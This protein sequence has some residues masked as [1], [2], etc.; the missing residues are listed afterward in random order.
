MALASCFARFA[1]SLLAWFCCFLS[2]RNSSLVISTDDA[3]NLDMFF[4]NSEVPGIIMTVK[5]IN[6]INFTQRFLK[7]FWKGETD[8][9]QMPICQASTTESSCWILLCVFCFQ[10]FFDNDL[11]ESQFILSS[12]AARCIDDKPDR[13]VKVR[14]LF[15][16]FCACKNPLH[17][18]SLL[19]IICDLHSSLKISRVQNKPKKLSNGSARW[20]VTASDF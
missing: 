2:S 12:K 20:T 16:K 14:Y 6:I 1:C 19:W 3:E 15:L 9:L 17:L 4:V 7:Y 5:I 18:L 11:S 13:N 10:L 8:L